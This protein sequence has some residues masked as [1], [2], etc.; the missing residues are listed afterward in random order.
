[1]KYFKPELLTRYRS[2]NDDEAAS[3]AKEWDEAIAAY[4]SRLQTIFPRLPREVQRLCSEFSLHDAQLFGVARKNTPPTICTWLRLDESSAEQARILE[5][6]YTPVTGLAGGIEID[7][8]DIA[9][10]S[11]ENQVFVLYDEVDR[12]ETQ[13][14]LTH[15]LLLSNGRELDIRFTDLAIE[16]FDDGMTPSALFAEKKKWTFETASTSQ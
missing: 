4:E 16:I 2:C 11:P 10:A 7:P 15:S 6:N 1:M 3:A 5:L 12:D 13:G 8:R 14:F 9:T